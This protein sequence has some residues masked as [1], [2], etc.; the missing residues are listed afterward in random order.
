MES[1]LRPPLLGILSSLEGAAPDRDANAFPTARKLPRHAPTLPM[2]PEIAPRR[3]RADR[4]L[5]VSRGQKH[6]RATDFP[7]S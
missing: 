4:E 3:Y 2:S 1:A 5:T 7:F 6:G